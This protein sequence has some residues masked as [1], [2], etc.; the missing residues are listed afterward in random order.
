MPDTTGRIGTTIGSADLSALVQE[1]VSRPGWRSGNHLTL[2]VNGTGRRAFDGAFGAAP[3]LLVRYLPPMSNTVVVSRLIEGS[4]VA[5]E[6]TKDG[7]PVA[8]NTQVNLGSVSRSYEHVGM[9]IEPVIVG[10]RFER[11][12]VPRNAHILEAYLTL[13]LELN[14]RQN[15]YCQVTIQAEKHADS[16]S[17]T[18]ATNDLGGRTKTATSTTWEL[19]SEL[20]YWFATM[21]SGDLSA[22][23]QEVTDQSTWASGNHLSL[24]VVND[25]CGRT[26]QHAGPLNGPDLVISYALKSP[27]LPPSPPP[28]SIPSPPPFPPPMP[29]PP[30]GSLAPGA[31][32]D[33]QQVAG[34]GKFGYAWTVSDRAKGISD[35]V[36]LPSSVVFNDRYHR[37]PTGII[38][39]YCEDCVTSHQHIFYKR[40]TRPESLEPYVWLFECWGNDTHNQQGMDFDL[41][42]TYADA[43]GGQNAWPFCTPLDC[44]SVGRLGHADAKIGAFGDC[45]SDGSVVPNQWI[46]VF[47]NWTTKLRG[48][49]HWAIYVEVAQPAPPP[50]PPYSSAESVLAQLYAAWQADSVYSGAWATNW[51]V[52]SPAC[53]AKSASEMP[54]APT[55]PVITDIT[56]ANPGDSRDCTHFA[57]SW[58]AKLWFD[59][60]YPT[61]G[62]VAHL[63]PDND[64]EPCESLPAQANAPVLWLRAEDIP[65]DPYVPKTDTRRDLQ[66]VTLWRD[67]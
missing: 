28:A 57:T 61:Y 5:Q 63:D 55:L 29:L 26:V 41:Y 38:Y 37:S 49:R 22:V 59:T 20:N 64:G 53:Y 47:G 34:N 56:P 62:D 3:E 24:F 23:V 11:I 44:S 58:E 66:N 15:T 33:W 43:I 6:F 8:S 51:S 39:R 32:G 45:S 65:V 30:I 25:D 17:W 2:L 12:D 19:P 54:Y 14:L 48:R 1:V 36:F 50:P 9:V 16:H 31:A 27:P 18:G 42:S 52:G 21:V 4:S 10:L 7:V 67:R 60:Y 13:H 40:H 35:S 46:S